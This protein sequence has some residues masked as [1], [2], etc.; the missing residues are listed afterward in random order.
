MLVVI[1]QIFVVVSIKD[2]IKLMVLII[3]YYQ[4]GLIM[5]GQLNFG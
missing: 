2:I 4:L 5:H 3:K 1:I